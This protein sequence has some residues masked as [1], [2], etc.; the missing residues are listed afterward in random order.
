MAS[1]LN[2]AKEELSKINME[3]QWDK[4]VALRARKGKIIKDDHAITIND[5]KSI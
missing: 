3:F 2:V 5:G 4:C 1:L